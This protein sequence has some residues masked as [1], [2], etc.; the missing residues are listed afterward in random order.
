M[1]DLTDE[2]FKS[3]EDEVMNQF[4][5][6]QRMLIAWKYCTKCEMF[7][8]PRAHHC[9]ACQQCVARMDHHCPWVGNCVGMYNH[10]HFLMFVTY[11]CLA[12]IFIFVTL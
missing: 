10:K 5:Y 12:L 6:T 1:F 9:S 11:G 3:I 7:R 4:S 8:P 2:E